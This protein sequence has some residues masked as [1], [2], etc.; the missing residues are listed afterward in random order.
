M[1]LLFL[2][3]AFAG[4]VAL[5]LQTKS[6]RW[7][8]PAEPEQPTPR[9]RAV[10]RRPAPPRV[11]QPFD[12]QTATPVQAEKIIS[13][14]AYVVDGDTITIN[15]NQIRLFGIDAPEINH[16][17]GQKSKWALVHLCKGRIVTAKVTEADEYGRFVAKCYLDDGRDLSGEMVDQGLAIDWPKFSGGI[18]KAREVEGVRKRLF[19]ADARQKGRM[20][21]WRR[22]EEKQKTQSR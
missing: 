15:K 6:T 22:F 9:P 7:T 1:E 2:A 8:P 10:R 19:L 20:D 17:Y 4:I 11:S 5:L 12:A 18:Y 21:V 3:A 13:G 16:P 14:R